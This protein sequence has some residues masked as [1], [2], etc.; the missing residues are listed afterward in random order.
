MRVFVVMIAVVSAFAGAL[1]S[2]QEAPLSLETEA[3]DIA[4]FV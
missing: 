4:L 3:T 1:L 2:R